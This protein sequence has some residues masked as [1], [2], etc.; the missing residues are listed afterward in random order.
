MLKDR[1]TI[2]QFPD[3]DYDRVLN[4]LSKRA[5]E[6]S[7]NEPYEGRIII[8]SDLIEQLVSHLFTQGQTSLRQYLAVLDD[9]Y[10]KAYLNLLESRDS[11]VEISE[12]MLHTV[13]KD[14]TGNGRI[15]FGF[16][17]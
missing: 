15:R 1:C 12:D 5:H 2:I 10:D 14:R 16:E 3:P 13:L 11:R 4:I 17:I 9:L 7:E 6:M 8:R